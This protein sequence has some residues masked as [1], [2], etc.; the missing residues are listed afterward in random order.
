MLK[1]NEAISLLLRRPRNMSVLWSD[2][3]FIHS[4]KSVSVKIISP[5]AAETAVYALLYLQQYGRLD[6]V[7]DRNVIDRGGGKL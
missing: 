6:D 2:T 1:D 4:K 7:S 3:F 5:G